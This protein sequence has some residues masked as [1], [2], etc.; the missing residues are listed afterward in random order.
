VGIGW[1]PTGHV[2]IFWKEII[3]KKIPPP[4]WTVKQ[5]QVLNSWPTGSARRRHT[6]GPR[7]PVSE[8]SRPYVGWWCVFHRKNGAPAKKKKKT[9]RSL[10]MDVS[11]CFSFSVSS[12]AGAN[13]VN[14]ILVLR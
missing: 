7:E 8:V 9:E 6:V 11:F 1:W 3:L 13:I 10:F 5:K 2:V 12:Q 14:S 4:T